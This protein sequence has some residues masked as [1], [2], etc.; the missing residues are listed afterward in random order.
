MGDVA[1]SFEK[2]IVGE[3]VRERKEGCV[4]RCLRR[5][6]RERERVRKTKECVMG[7]EKNRELLLLSICTILNIYMSTQSIT[8]II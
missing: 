7:K 6:E 5:R 3:E 4:R 8:T 1:S 2:E